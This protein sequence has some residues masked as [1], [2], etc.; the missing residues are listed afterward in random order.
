M[1]HALKQHPFKLFIK[2]DDLVGQNDHVLL[3]RL[4]EQVGFFPSFGFLSQASTVMDALITATTGAKAGLSSTKEGEINKILECVTLAI[5]DA[6][7]EQKEARLLAIKQHERDIAN[8]EDKDQVLDY[9]HI[10]KIKYP[11]IIIDDF[12]DKENMRGHYI[13]DIIS[14]WAGLLAEHR[15]AH[16]IFISDNPSSSRGTLYLN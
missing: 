1:N 15:L 8:Q 14:E 3:S 16:V 10:P 11:A 12:L 13:Y 6:V 4:A 7:A 2:C 9:S 5:N